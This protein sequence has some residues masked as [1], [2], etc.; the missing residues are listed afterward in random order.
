MPI[1]WHG[2]YT[3]PL[4]AI[5]TMKVKNIKSLWKD[6]VG[7]KIIAAFLIFLLT[8]IGNTLYSLIQQKSFW[9]SLSSFW[10][11][12]LPLWLVVTFIF[13]LLVLRLILE[14]LLLK[15]K[16]KFEYDENSFLLDQQTFKSFKYYLSL[17]DFLQ[18]IKDENF[19]TARFNPKMLQ[20]LKLLEK[21]YSKLELEFLNPYLEELKL[22]FVNPALE[23][24]EKLGTN[25]FQLSDKVHG[26]P[27]EWEWEQP[28]KFVRVANELNDSATDFY[29][30]YDKFVRECRK[31]FMIN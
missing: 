14:K 9:E 20:S 6:P 8:L 22:K 3:K 1:S 18:W 27:P 15:K 31:I 26:L 13:S 5:R 19:G 28:E 11:F 23:F 21:E 4:V 29:D 12:E 30:N 24:K 17:N 10:N 25:T 2:A 7:S 16:S